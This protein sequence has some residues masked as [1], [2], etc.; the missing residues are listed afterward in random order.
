L[1][2]EPA[3]A[4]AVLVPADVGVAAALPDAAEPDAGELAAVLGAVAELP[5]E[6]HAA[7]PASRQTPTA[8]ICHLEPALI[9]RDIPVERTMAAAASLR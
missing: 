1:V 5:L 8:A 6:L 3:K 7:A 4:D 9:R 2:T